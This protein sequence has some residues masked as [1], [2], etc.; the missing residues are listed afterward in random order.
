MNLNQIFYELGK[1]SGTTIR[2][3]QWLFHSLF[4]DKEKA[5]KSENLIG[6][7][8]SEAIKREYQIID[9]QQYNNLLNEASG[10]L[11]MR[12]KNENR[13]FSFFVIQSDDLNAFALPGGYIFVTYRLLHLCLSD[14]AELAFILAHEMVHVL[15][16]HALKRILTDTSLNAIERIIKT[17][18]I[19]GNLA[20]QTISEVVRKRYSRE[21]EIQADK[22]AVQWLI[23]SGFNPH[24]A[25]WVLEKMNGYNDESD[26]SFSYFS[27][28]PVPSERVS[29]IKKEIKD[30][31]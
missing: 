21:N 3:G 24:A 25:L 22:I 12:V 19:V 29:R 17:Q 20:R 9:D 8:L 1:K 26:D 30:N 5:L 2:K 7:A 13:R 6:K 23:S 27:T 14:R 28:H 15:A 16:G 18:S 31:I 4:G 10:P 11:I